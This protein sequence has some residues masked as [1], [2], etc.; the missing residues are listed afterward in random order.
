MLLPAS[1]SSRLQG[2]RENFPGI[3]PGAE[4]SESG[5]YIVIASIRKGG[6]MGLLLGDLYPVVLTFKRNKAS[7]VQGGQFYEVH[8]FL[9]CKCS[10][11]L[12]LN[13]NFY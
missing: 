13:I 1:P 5:D 2:K 3:S 9:G 6:E 11:G 4:F 7:Y 8:K 12:V 10:S